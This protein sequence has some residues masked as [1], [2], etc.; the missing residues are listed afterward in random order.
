MKKKVSVSIPKDLLIDI[1]SDRGKIPR[2]L[3]IEEKLKQAM[4]Q[5]K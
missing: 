3:Y 2:L 5:E 1:D 4:R